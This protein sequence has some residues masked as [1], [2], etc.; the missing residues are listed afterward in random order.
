[1]S[2]RPMTTDIIRRL[3]RRL[4][5]TPRRRIPDQATFGSQATIIRT[6]PVTC[7]GLVTGRGRPISVRAGL[8]RGITADVTMAATGGA[9][10]D[11]GAANLGGEP[12]L[13]PAPAA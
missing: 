12:A 10:T 4:S 7:G 6:A 5:I 3:L 9:N 2:T 8:G 13:Q 1:M 11:C